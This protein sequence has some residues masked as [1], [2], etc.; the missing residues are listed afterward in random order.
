LVIHGLTTHNTN[1]V[2]M[3]VLTGL[4]TWRTTISHATTCLEDTSGELTRTVRAT[5]GRRSHHWTHW[6]SHFFTHP[7]VVLKTV[8][9]THGR[10][11]PH[12]GSQQPSPRDPSAK[13][14][15]GSPQR[16]PN[17]QYN[18]AHSDG[19]CRVSFSPEVSL[20][21]QAMAEKRSRVKNP[22]SS[23]AHRPRSYPHTEIS[24]RAA[25][26]ISTTLAATP[27]SKNF[28]TLV[29][30]HSSTNQSQATST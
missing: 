3:L 17:K 29:N 4:G 18:R 8:L 14:L 11:Q 5:T 6:Q 13:P 16:G 28:H 27:G 25:K 7:K 9:P 23:W 1:L 20:K 2:G 30:G 26:S 10:L 21:A 19:S 22:L 24:P 12:P 15:W